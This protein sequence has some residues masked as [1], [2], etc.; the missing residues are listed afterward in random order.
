MVA[1]VV[2][3]WLVVAWAAPGAETPATEATYAATSRASSP[4][5]SFAGI[6]WTGCSFPFGPFVRPD[7]FETGKRIWPW[8]MFR[9]VDSLNPCARGPENASSRFGPIVPCVPASLSV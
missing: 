9:I 3:G 7:G 2:V 4:V 6:P 1:W 8:T 5:T